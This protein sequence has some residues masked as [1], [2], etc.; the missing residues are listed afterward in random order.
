MLTDRM[1]FSIHDQRRGIS[2]PVLTPGAGV[3]E[4]S[5]CTLTMQPISKPILSFAVSY[6]NSSTSPVHPSFQ[7][8]R[9]GKIRGILKMLEAW[10][11]M[12]TF[13]SPRMLKGPAMGQKEQDTNRSPYRI[14][15]SRSRSRGDP[16]LTR[17]PQSMLQSLLQRL[18]KNRNIGKDRGIR[19]YGTRGFRRLSSGCVRREPSWATPTADPRLLHWP[20]LPKEAD[21]TYH[22]DNCPKSM[23]CSTLNKSRYMSLC[24]P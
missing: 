8:S 9:A 10:S 12:T 21:S 1:M 11:T 3:I 23:D 2:C 5:M 17:T 19:C 4:T 22:E 6:G 13:P 14:R 24:S 18:R 20:S 16:S 7:K 15:Q